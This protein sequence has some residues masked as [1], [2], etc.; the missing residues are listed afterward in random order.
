MEEFKNSE[1]SGSAKQ[2]TIPEENPELSVDDVKQF[3]IDFINKLEIF[4]PMDR[5]IPKNKNQAVKRDDLLTKLGGLSP[6]PGG[7][8][9]APFSPK[10]LQ[11]FNTM[12]DQD[13]KL[14]EN[15]AQ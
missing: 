13:Y 12:F 2:A 4:D 14:C 11:K 3:F 15:K 1:E 5:A 9:Y 10:Q 7:G 8:V 6:V